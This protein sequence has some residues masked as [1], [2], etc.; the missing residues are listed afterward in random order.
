MYVPSL[1]NMIERRDS[2]FSNVDVDNASVGKN[3]YGLR[4]YLKP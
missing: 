1:A 3:K 2:E 4:R